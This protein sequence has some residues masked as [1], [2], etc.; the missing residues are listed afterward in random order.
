MK[1]V[2]LGGFLGSGKTTAIVAACQS[3][4]KRNRNVAI[5]T[6]DQGDQQVD[7]A[8]FRSTGLPVEEVMNGCFCCNYNQLDQ[9]LELLINRYQPDFIFAESAGSCT[10]LVA[11]I[12]KPLNDLRPELEVSIS[13]FADV[14]LL[15]SI[16]E[17][18]SFFLEE[19]VRYIY[20]K[21]LEEA[22]ILILNKVDLVTQEQLHS[23]EKALASEYPGKTIIRQNSMSPEGISN[24]LDTVEN[25]SDHRVRK[26][27]SVDYDIYGEGEARLAW[28]D[29]SV[30]I[31]SSRND[32]VFIAH[33][34][35]GF[36]FDG[37]QQQ[38]LP[39]GHLKFFLK[40]DNWDEK[41]SFTITST[42]SNL[43]HQTKASATVTLLINARVQ[44][45]PIILQKLVDDV[46]LRSEEL[47]DCKLVRNDWKVFKP[48]YPRP[49]HRIA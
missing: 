34:I 11:T 26:S 20:K 40:A 46:L 27:L 21:Q 6:N 43:P 22:D 5:I 28:L 19:S 16:M 41:I 17:G 9:H 18:R 13:V 37:I 36:V 35:V 15:A 14:E 38:Q 33:K 49:T 32:A 24:W 42:S 1:L 10:D 44:T 48:G 4:I 25:F 29:K 12:A 8:F 7:T 31:N 30:T 23:V 45:E 2:L 3:L 39:I 47:F